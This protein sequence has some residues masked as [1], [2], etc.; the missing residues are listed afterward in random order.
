MEIKRLLKHFAKHGY[1]SPDTLKIM[2]YVGYDDEE[3]LHDLVEELGHKKAMEFVSKALGKLSSTSE[4][5]IKIDLSNVISDGSW[6]Y[7]DI[8]R[9]YIDLDEEYSDV[10]IHSGWGENKIIDP[11]D[12]SESTIEELSDNL[13]LGEMNNWE[14]FIDSVRGECY[15]HIKENCGFGI[16][17]I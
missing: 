4:I 7:L 11:E 17:F 15:N 3:L 6:V 9:F 1:P 10:L 12:G 16:W 14:E 2:K 13:D 8:Y 5:S